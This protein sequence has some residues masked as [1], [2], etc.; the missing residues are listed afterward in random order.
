MKLVIVESP[1][2]AKTIQKYLGGD[3]R[4]MASGG[5]ICDLPEKS[6]GINIEQNFKPDYVLSKNKKELVKD[7][8]LAV[9]KSDAVYLATDPDR[10]GEAISW[11]LE[12]ILEIP[13]ENN[14]IEFHEISQKA[15]KKAISEPRSLNMNLVNA[16]QARRVLDRLVGYK[17][18][19][20]LNKKIRSGLS[21]GRVQSAALRMI[22]DREREIAAFKPEEYW[23]IFAVLNDKPDARTFQAA[24]QE[25]NG[26]KFKVTNKTDADKIVAEMRRAE[27][28]V[29]KVVRGA[30]K[31][32]PA[33]PFT[34]STL[35]QDGSR[36]LS[37]SSPQVMQIAQQLYEGIDIPGMGH[38]ALV[39]YI[40]T[41]S[42]R[43]SPEF[44]QE[45]LKWIGQTYGD[46]YAPKKPNF[47]SSKGD[48]VQDAHEAIR[49][50]S[51][52]LTP[53]SLKDK[54][55]RNHLRLYK[56][57]YN[58]FVASQMAEAQYS[59]L[60]V[61]ITAHSE[62][63][64]L[65]FK[66]T[67]RTLLFNGFLAVYEIEN[68]DDEKEKI[69][70]N[71][72]LPNLQEGQILHFVDAK[73]EQKFT[74][75]PARF[76]NATLIKG[77]E[78]NGIGR[79]STYASVVSVLTKREYVVIEQK[80]FKPTAL[81]E[82]VTDFM[83][84][85]F[86]NIVDV[87]FTAKMEADLDKIEQKGVA[88]QNVISDFWPGLEKLLKDAAFNNQKVKLEAEVTDVICEKC[89]ANMVIK[90]GRYGKFLACP[91]YPQCKNVKN[92]DEVVG[93]CPKCGGNIVKKRSKAGKTFYGC[94]NYPN[95]DFMSWEI[96]APYFCPKCGQTMRILKKN[97]K[98]EYVCTSK[99]CNNVI[100]VSEEKASDEKED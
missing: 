83:L 90:E 88:W 85:N 87:N 57:I 65:G 45:T 40:R 61:H 39:T 33:P 96:P 10:E 99:T 19:P 17:I 75:P 56:L 37:L 72:K 98:T 3:F 59:T 18:S 46:A 6:L 28:T 62:K 51:L 89:G 70:D 63:A 52:E 50:I 41:D 32:H 92:I 22:V 71:S 77:M 82:A 36:K 69:E 78:E 35:Q 67:G 60:N 80:A 84:K 58:R 54:L 38:V 73:S 1:S 76:T 24:F 20:I 95:C 79:P 81:G 25:V 68:E 8:K 97:G 12:N 93:K 44:Q 43:I 49:P 4:V 74:K 13:N 2:K 23:N 5:H 30:S 14:R 26:K 66:L 27:Y 34:T 100:L 94:G 21:A 9:K 29:D 64:D 91:N 31:S 47:Y 86:E 48:N 53:E 11:H 15:V 42:V 7:L 16:Q 55:P